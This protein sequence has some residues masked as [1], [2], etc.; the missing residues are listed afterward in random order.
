MKIWEKKILL[1]SFMEEGKGLKAGFSLIEVLI[2]VVLLALAAAITL[3]RF[4]G[5]EPERQWD[6]VLDKC[7]NYL[8]VARQRAISEQKTHRLFLEKQKESQDKLTIQ[9]KSDKKDAKGNEMY[10]TVDLS[11]FP[12]SYLLPPGM[13]WHA[14]YHTSAEEQFAL[15]KN[16][17]SIIITHEGMVEETTLLLKETREGQAPAIS[18]VVEPFLGTMKKVAG[19]LPP[20]KRKAA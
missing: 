15:N 13:L 1:Q 16:T 9:Q 17:A 11:F 18:F 3:P 5:K 20:P 19:H 10:E 14:L 4:L 12:A 2:T 7:N 6:A 8:S